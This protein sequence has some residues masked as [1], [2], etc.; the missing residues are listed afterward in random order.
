MRQERLF[1]NP[2]HHIAIMKKE[3]GLMEL[4]FCGEKTV[5]SRFYH[6]KSIPWDDV[7]KKDIIFFKNTGGMV[8]GRAE[9]AKV[10]QFENLTKEKIQSILL[11]YHK[12]L[13]LK[14]TEIPYFLELNKDKRYCILIFLKDTQKVKPFQIDKTGLPAM[15]G[16]L[17]VDDIN[18]IVL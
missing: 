10:L 11:K 3:W 16:W 2:K 12:A 13:G 5:E 8:E 7:A 6:Q 14:N 4:V 15:S 18:N 9:V 17:T 1:R